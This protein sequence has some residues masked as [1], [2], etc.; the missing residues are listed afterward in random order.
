VG[1]IYLAISV[2]LLLYMRPRRSRTGE[3]APGRPR[4]VELGRELEPT[5]RHFDPEAEVSQDDLYA[6][7]SELESCRGSNWLRFNQIAS[8][9]LILFP[10]HRVEIGLD[11]VVRDSVLDSVKTS[12][13]SDSLLSFSKQ[14]R[15]LITLFPDTRA[16]LGLG[17]RIWTGMKEELDLSAGFDW[18]EFCSMASDL[19]I[20]FPRRS[21]RHCV[22]WLTPPPKPGFLAACH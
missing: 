15:S 12:L 14:A 2:L 22:T 4:A 20:L 1:L 7:K 9:L 11:E 8:S 3:Q 18:Y 13:R 16:E 17:E 19:V 10:D 21:L 5:P 6:I